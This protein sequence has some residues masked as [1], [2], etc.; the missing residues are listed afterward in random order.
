MRYPETATIASVMSLLLLAAMPALAQ[1]QEND[2]S[3]RK[4][5][6][7][8][9]PLEEIRPADPGTAAAPVDPKSYVIGAEDQLR[10]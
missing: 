5:S 1:N 3:E 8:I 7:T 10:I 6:S 9:A 2:R 4:P